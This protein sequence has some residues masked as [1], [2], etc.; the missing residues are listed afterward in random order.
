MTT[1]SSEEAAYL[2]VLTRAEGSLAPRWS[3]LTELGSSRILR[4][5][6]LWFLAVPPLASL[7]SKLGPDV[8]L[9]LFGSAWVLRLDLPFS[10]K[11]FYFAAAAFAIATSIF[12]L[13]CPEIV[14]RYSTYTQFESEGKGSRQIRDYFLDFLAR[15]RLD[16]LSGVLVTNYLAEFAMEYSKEAEQE[17]LGKRTIEDKDS[18]LDLVMES[19]PR[20]MNVTDAF[21]YVHRVSDSAN[22]LSAMACGLFFLLGFVLISVVLVQNFVYVW[23]LTLPS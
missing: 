12:F 21:W 13:R 2:S 7:V 14:R 17:E 5:S 3:R 18:L 10:W 15:R 1:D 20:S 6:Y 8:H 9:D 23:K 11:I 4:S 19:T 16:Q 22:P